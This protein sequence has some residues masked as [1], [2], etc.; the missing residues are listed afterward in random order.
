MERA[1][2]LLVQGLQESES[3]IANLGAALARMARTLG[4]A[5]APLFQITGAVQDGGADSRALRTALAQDMA[6]C[7]Q[8]LQFHDRLT[9]KLSLARDILTGA[10]PD[11]LLTKVPNRPANESGPEGSIELF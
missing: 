8:N 11:S 9:Q 10:Q 4:D 3:P 5:G 6:L 7:I 2:V 1:T